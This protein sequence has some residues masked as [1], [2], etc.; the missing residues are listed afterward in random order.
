MKSPAC[1]AQV[2]NGRGGAASRRAAG[3]L[4]RFLLRLALVFIV[5]VGLW[6][7]VGDLYRSTLAAAGNALGRSCSTGWEV[8]VTPFEAW[9]EFNEPS[10]ADLVVLVRRPTWVD[11]AGR[12][13][14]LLAK[15]VV[16]FSQPYAATAFLVALFAAP[17]F[18]WR[19][20]WLRLLVAAAALHVVMAGLVLIDVVHTLAMH[21]GWPA[22]SRGILEIVSLLHGT[23][24]DWPMGVFL[25]PFLIWVLT[26]VCWR[27]RK[28][29]APR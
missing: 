10:N 18:G 29:N 28:P 26:D 11:A 16:T 21:G 3:P 17:P 22:P 23:I 5:L 25:L 15:R 2:R 13:Q 4:L 27:G 9:A 19:A 14:Y 6:P 12:A 24:T 1:A 8:V 7:A 20:R